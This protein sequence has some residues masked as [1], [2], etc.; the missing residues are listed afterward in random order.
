MPRM[1]LTALFCCLRAIAVAQTTAPA[2][3]VAPVIE[4]R[5]SHHGVTIV[6]NYFWLREKSNPE[7]IKYLDAENAYTDA[8]TRELKP[9][10]DSLYKEMLGR[11]KQTDLSVPTRRGVYLYYSRTEEGKQY[12]VQCRKKG[13]MDAAEEILL[14]MNEV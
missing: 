8:M 11:I 9:F 6:D 10:E 3:P 1:S 12:P 14:D 7:V 2:A 5:E 13:G 4:H